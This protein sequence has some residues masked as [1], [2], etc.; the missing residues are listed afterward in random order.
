M[1]SGIGDSLSGAEVFWM[2]G[3]WDV[4]LG[5]IAVVCCVCVVAVADATGPAAAV[6]GKHFDCCWCI[7]I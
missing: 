1:D 4:F 3:S 2:G 7:N 6:S 5:S